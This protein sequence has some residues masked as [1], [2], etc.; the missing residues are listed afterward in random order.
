MTIST[1]CLPALPAPARRRSRKLFLWLLVFLCASTL[2]AQPTQDDLARARRAV[3]Q[4]RDLDRNPTASD[5]EAPARSLEPFLALVARDDRR[6]RLLREDF[7]IAFQTRELQAEL[8]RMARDTRR[9]RKLRQI[10]AVLDNDADL[11]AEALVRPY[12][13]ERRLRGFFPARSEADPAAAESAPESFDRWVERRTSASGGPEPRVEGLVLPRVIGQGTDE[14]DSW[15]RELPQGPPAKR[16]QSM[17]WTGSELIVWGGTIAS[18]PSSGLWTNA[19]F[20]YD[21]VCDAWRPIRLDDTTPEPRAFHSA[22]WTGSEMIVWGGETWSEDADPPYFVALGDGGRYDPAEDRWLPVPDVGA[23]GPRLEHTAVWTGTEMIVWGGLTPEAP[24]VFPPPIFPDYTPLDD[25]ARYDPAFGGWTSMGGSPPTARGRAAAAWTGDTLFVVGGSDGT[26]WLDPDVDST[27][28]AS[29]DPVDDSWDTSLPQPPAGGPMSPPFEGPQA[30][31]TG[32]SLW[33]AQPASGRLLANYRFGVWTQPPPPPPPSRSDRRYSSLAWTGRRLILWGGLTGMPGMEALDAGGLILDSLDNSWSVIAPG[34]PGAPAGRFAHFGVWTG[35]ELLI[36]GGGRATDPV[37]GPT[38]FAAA[39]STGA[40]FQPN[41]NPG[42]DTGTWAAMPLPPDAAALG[43]SMLWTGAELLLWGGQRGLDVVTGGTRYDPTLDQWSSTSELGQPAARSG[44]RAVWTGSEMLLWAGQDGSGTPLDSGG[45]YQPAT[46]SWSPMGGSPPAARSEHTAVWTGSELLVWGGFDDTGAGLDSGGR[47]QPGSDS[48]SATGG[49]PPAARGGQSGVWTGEGLLIFGGLTGCPGACAPTGD[50]AIYDPVGDTWSSLA[51]PGPTAERWAHTAVWTGEE[52]IA[53]GGTNGYDTTN[54]CLADGVAIDPDAATITPLPANG[55]GRCHAAAVWNGAEMIVWGGTDRVNVDAELGGVPP[56]QPL[57][58]GARL[59]PLTGLWTSTPDDDTTPPATQRHTAAWSGEEVFLWG[60]RPEIS[61]QLGVYYTDTLPFASPTLEVD[62]VADTPVLLGGEAETIRFDHDLPTAFYDDVEGPSRF[63]AARA[64]ASADGGGW[65]VSVAG[66]CS[67]ASDYT[68]PLSAWRFGLPGACNYAGAADTFTLTSAEPFE[69]TASTLLQ[70]RY[71]L[72]TDQV[73]DV[74]EQD[75]ARIEVSGDDGATW[76]PVAVD[77]LHRSSTGG[78]L[79]P[80]PLDDTGETWRG[81]SV[82]LADFAGPSTEGRIRFVFERRG[83]LNQGLGWLL[84]DIGIGEPTG[85]GRIP[86]GTLV[87]SDGSPGHHRVGAHDLWDWPF[88]SWDLDADGVADN[89]T[90]ARP[91]F[92]IT[93]AD[94]ATYGL[95]Q[96]GQHPV[97][98]TVFDRGGASDTETVV[99]EVV[100]GEPPT[101]TL[102]SPNGGEAWS[103]ASTQTITWSASDNIGLS[104]FELSYTNEETGTGPVPIVCDEPLDGDARSCTWELPD[105]TSTAMRVEI[106]A[107]DRRPEPGGPNTASDSSDGPFYLVQASSDQVRTLVVWHRERTEARHGTS[108]TDA[109]AAA[110][111]TYA[112]HGKVDGVVLDLAN[113]PSLAPLY[114]DWDT[115]PWTTGTVDDLEA[116]INRAN[117]LATAIRLYLFEQISTSFTNLEFLVLVGGDPLV[118]YWRLEEDLPRY[119]ESLYIEELQSFGFLDDASSPEAFCDETESALLATFCRDRYPADTP[120]GSSF[121]TAV[122][123]SSFTWWLPD[124]AVG[125]LVETPAQMRGLI[126][127]FI[128]QD[129]VTTVDRALT[130]GYD[131]LTDGGDAVN[132]LLNAELDTGSTEITRLSQAVELWDDED[133]LG[134]LFGVPPTAATDLA[135]IDGHADHRAEGAADVGDGGILSTVE[136]DAAARTNRGA[137]LIGVG[138]HSGLSV[139]ADGGPGDETDPAFLLDLPE[140][141]ARGNYPVLI[142]NG[143]FGWGLSEGVGLG[144]QL[145]LLI[146]DEIVR[147]GQLAVGEALRL[148]KQEYFL[149]QDRLDAF[150]HKVIHEAMLYGLPNYEVRVE[151]ALE[152]TLEGPREGSWAGDDPP[153]VFANR[154]ERDAARAVGPRVPGRPWLGDPA[155]STLRLPG[156]QVL[157]KSSPRSVAAGPE[158]GGGGSLQILDFSFQAFERGQDTDDDPGTADWQEAYRTFEWCLDEDGESRLCQGT[159]G[160][161]PVGTFFTLNGLASSESGLPIQ[162][163][164]SFDSRLFGTE[165]HGILIRGGEVLQPAEIN[166]ED[167]ERCTDVLGTVHPCFDPVIGNPETEVDETEGPAPTPFQNYDHPTPFL[168][169]DHPTSNGFFESGAGGDPIRFDTLNA[170]MGAAMRR[171]VREVD[172]ERREIFSQWLFRTRDF[173][174]YYSSSN[175]WTPPEIGEATHDCLEELPDADCY[176]TLSGT[177]ATFSV[178]VTDDGD[179]VFRVFVTHVQDVDANGDGAWRTFEL[180]PGGGDLYTGTLEVSGETFYLLQA[181]DRAGNIGSVWVRGDDVDAEGEAIGSS[182]ELPQLFP[183]EPGEDEEE[184]GFFADGFES[185]DTSAWSG[186]SP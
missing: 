185:G 144:E 67:G 76:T 151:R 175:D 58:S 59:D 61:G 45:R 54:L 5:G 86:A 145:V 53:W 123:G 2:G 34:T 37:A 19:G 132:A 94:L 80:L 24:V 39:I 95:D 143:G 10:F 74:A 31:W 90:P 116:S 97:S 22:V 51:S 13:V 77:L 46:D 63:V 155:W 21:P 92:E 186:T 177:T 165:L 16:G 167:P 64:G 181:V 101:V 108:E 75:T 48:W 133:L 114:D 117:A 115:T 8:D 150:D 169:Y 107:R 113:V 18:P 30:L 12:L 62:G 111:S 119:P 164:I 93:E 112:G 69:L 7:G 47:Y 120:Y 6:S 4:L 176:H 79:D 168:N 124:L 174:N 1:P 26:S 15:T 146:A 100:D 110:L 27:T 73:G 78:S 29:Y 170:P 103:A 137:V 161:T 98:L 109:L 139:E 82:A 128:A 179:G 127:V 60:G 102:L 184:M 149:R 85:D 121:T 135:F 152:E 57:S 182:F 178:P 89:P 68:S 154:T 106:T 20:S 122:P 72:E 159:P 172:E 55:E 23:P 66:T 173:T 99:L 126:D 171:G 50:A 166:P 130:S 153:R 56:A 147:G 140:M 83:T 17:V 129:G 180:L 160:E 32:E 84:D 136:M 125:R 158:G 36:W 3:E 14:P 40:R 138:C 25:G 71:F 142:G 33:V 163:L 70:L 41:W 162:P 91:D 156:G 88:F 157:R 65:F 11:I 131:F 52:M 9:P 49:S 44:H 183:I 43:H 104:G 28:F 148:A 35:S 105:L 118:P 81:F 96:P 134:H 38:R 87:A 42:A 141:L